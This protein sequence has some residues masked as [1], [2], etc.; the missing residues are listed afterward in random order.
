MM[1]LKTFNLPKALEKL[2]FLASAQNRKVN[3]MK[4]I[5]DN[6][7][8]VAGL[9]KQRERSIKKLEEFKALK[10]SGE[11]IPDSGKLINVGQEI[12]PFTFYSDGGILYDDQYYS[13]LNMFAGK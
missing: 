2:E 12:K 9:A 5:Q 10:A 8:A 4:F 7:L 1:F 11:E 13:M 6:V 3:T